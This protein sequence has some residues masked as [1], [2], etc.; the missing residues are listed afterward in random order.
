M[1][2]FVILR[3][4]VTPLVIDFTSPDKLTNNLLILNFLITKYEK[5]H[6][7]SFLITDNFV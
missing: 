7:K 1:V 2:S 3:H 5:C 6:K 4:P